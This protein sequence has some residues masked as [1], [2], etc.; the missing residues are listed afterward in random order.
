MSREVEV[1]RGRSRSIRRPVG[2][3]SMRSRSLYMKYGCAVASPN[4]AIR[5]GRVSVSAFA[6]L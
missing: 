4:E 2:F 5:S 1:R 6:T 3:R